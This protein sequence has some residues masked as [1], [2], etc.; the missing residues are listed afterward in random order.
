MSIELIAH[1]GY[2]K[3]FP[4][5]TLVAIAAALDSGARYFEIDIQLTRDG[6][7]VLFHDRKLK[8]MCDAAGAVH[9]YTLAELKQF[10]VSEP[11]KFGD[12]FKH[13]RI[14]TLEDVVTLL[15]NRPKVTA[16]VELKRSSLEKHGKGVVLD[17]VVKMLKPVASQCVLISFSL[18]TMLAARRRHWSRIGIVIDKWKQRNQKIIDDIKPEFLFCDADGLPMWGTLY[19]GKVNLVVYEVSN[20]K[21][22]RKLAKRGVDFAETFAIGELIEE[23][24]PKK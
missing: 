4:E 5:N 12:Q 2:A 16:F 8:R 19:T 9:D 11:E 15:K 22:A 23:L 6:H 21:Q 1:R 3:H 13:V 17:T 14:T 10:S 7:P 24:R 20:A 18:E